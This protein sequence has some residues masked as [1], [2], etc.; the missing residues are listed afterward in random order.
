MQGIFI[1]YQLIQSVNNQVHQSSVLDK[2]KMW[3]FVDLQVM[4]DL[5]GVSKGSGFVAFSTPEEASRAVSL[6][7]NFA[8]EI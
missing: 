3:V 7:S 8:F 4:R 1:W 5:N 2:L 6:Y